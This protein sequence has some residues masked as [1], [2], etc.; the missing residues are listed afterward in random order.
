MM[1]SSNFE[2]QTARQMLNE[3]F[4]EILVEREH[5]NCAISTIVRCDNEA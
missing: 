5:P 3:I 4:G 2:Q 1:A